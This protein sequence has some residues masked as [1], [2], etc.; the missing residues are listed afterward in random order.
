M[1]EI[2]PLPVV[3]NLNLRDRMD[4]PNSRS[5]RAD[6]ADMLGIEHEPAADSDLGL[7]I[8]ERS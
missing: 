7:S 2:H 1:V 4:F 3:L 8:D 6:G 5:L